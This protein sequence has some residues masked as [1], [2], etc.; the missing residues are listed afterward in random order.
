MINPLHLRLFGLGGLIVGSAVLIAWLAHANWRR[1]GELHEG[2]QLAQR[3]EE[4]VIGLHSE[5]NR[6]SLQTDA[7]SL[8]VL[9]RQSRELGSWIDGEI[10]EPHTLRQRRML[11]RIATAYAVFLTNVEALAA[12]RPTSGAAWLARTVA[13]EEQLTGIL[14]ESV[15][16]FLSEVH[17]G[18]LLRQSLTFVLLGLLLVL[19]AWLAAAVYLGM[20]APLR[21]RLIEAGNAVE[22]SQKLAALGVLAAGIAHEIRNPLT[23]IKAR[24]FTH[25]RSLMK[26]TTAYENTEFIGRELDRLERIVRDFLLFARPTDPRLAP[27]SAGGLLREVC[28][29]LGAELGRL[30]IELRVENP[31]DLQVQADRQHLHQVLINLVRNAADS[32]GADGRILLRARRARTTLRGESREVVILEVEDN[33]RGIPPEIRP[34]LFDPFFTTKPNGTGL[35]LSIAARIVE[36]HGG[37][38]RYHTK[39]NHGTTFGVVLPAGGAA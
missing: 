3:F 22:Q 4:Q 15:A 32:V 21:R 12:E 9:T 26:G 36:K 35:G 17:E 24:L 7:A 18:L 23:A 37:E 20:I 31:P 14:R 27:V 1:F 6:L 25:Q 16:E 29:L 39:M 28:E 33:G 5:L 13:L 10:R 30:G 34:R 2:L 38:L 8:P 11:E 19:L